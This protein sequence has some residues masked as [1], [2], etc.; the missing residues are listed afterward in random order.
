MTERNPAG[1]QIRP[2]VQALRAVAVAAVVLYHFWSPVITG[3]YVGVDVF[4]VI[5]GFLITGQLLREVS[6]SGRIGLA[7]FWARRARR[8]LPASLLVLLITAVG[9]LI[10]VPEIFWVQF[11]RETIA[12]ALYVENWV[13]SGDAVNYL[14]ANDVPSAVQHYW[15]LS[16]EEQFYVVWPLAILIA[17]WCARRLR[18]FSGRWAVLIV[19]SAITGVSLAYSVYLTETSPAPAYFVTPTR[20]WE[21]GLGGILAVIIARFDGR[22]GRTRPVIAWVGWAAIGYAVLRFTASTP[23]PG[24]T[25]LLPVVGTLAVIWAGTPSGWL[26]PTWIVGWR[27]IQWVGDVSYSV[28]LWH[29]PL[30]VIA[31]YVLGYAQLALP[32]KTSL[33]ALTMVLAYLTKRW[34]EDPV[35]TNRRLAIR[36]ARWTYF[37]ATAAMIA[38]IVPSLVGSAIVQANVT[39]DNAARAV[40]AKS[41]CFGAASLEH[42]NLCGSASFPV[43][44]PDP[45]LAPQDSPDI[46]F[47]NPPC[48]ATGEQVASC[49][50]GDPRSRIRVA[51]I[52]DS[53]AAQ[54][55]PALKE[56][57][58]RRGWNLT[59]YLKTNCAFADVR[60]SAAYA[61]C[62]VWSQNV[63]KRLA[64]AVP[65]NVVLTSFFADNMNIEIHNRSLTEAAA[66]RGFQDAWKPLV[67]RGSTVIVL[68]DIPHMLS[69][70]TVCVATSGDSRRCDVPRSAATAAPDL[71]YDAAGGLRGVLRLDLTHVFCGISTCDAVIG[72]VAVRT[73]PYHMTK[74]YAATTTPYLFADLQQAVR[75]ERRAPAW[76]VQAFAQGDGGSVVA[77]SSD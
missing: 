61:S 23:F 13:L 20:A 6:R 8:L 14:A 32:E 66:K 68:R 71:E 37:A 12:S 17:L 47:A 60:R 41:P 1:R 35:R 3:G 39:R 49:S 46:Y 33:L 44:S 40:L 62:D 69:S 22:F 19:L 52:G 2:E 11:F 53:H 48:F 42:A 50:F 26:A 76:L 73:D 67:D 10:W 30:L 58:E 31:P 65:F 18:W 56:I 28:Y 34:V 7:Q 43:I 29:W 59:L 15:S 21:F 38:V 36:K 45:A 5:S 72:G 16:V 25:A 24:Y 64:Q 9:V 57:A 75:A 27:P 70:T 63:S 74:T 4:F 77:K 54:W 55:E 51:L